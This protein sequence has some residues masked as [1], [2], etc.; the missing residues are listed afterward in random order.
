MK[1]RIF[2]LLVSVLAVLTLAACNG[3]DDTQKQTSDNN[4]TQT[5]DNNQTQKEVTATPSEDKE[6]EIL[7]L[8]VKESGYAM[9]EGDLYSIAILHNPNTEHS[10]QRPKLRITARDEAGL[11]LGTDEQTLSILYP[12]QDFYFAGHAFSTEET[13]VSVEIEAIALDDYNILKTKQQ[14][15]PNYKPLT[16]INT[17]VRDR[18]VMGEVSNSNDYAMG[19]AVVTVVFRDDN[20]KLVAGTSKFVDEIPASGTVPFDL[21]VYAGPITDHYEVF[22][23]MWDP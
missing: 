14:N 6:K 2:P 10:I 16:A 5:S 7:P 15:H 17:I 19:S 13:P 21:S 1:K 23:A 11:V 8:V 4:Q 18:R 22:A 12:Q 20:G 9:K 3:G